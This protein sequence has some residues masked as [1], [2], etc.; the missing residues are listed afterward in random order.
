MLP[1][2]GFIIHGGDL[3]KPVYQDSGRQMYPHHLRVIQRAVR[4]W[5]E[6]RAPE[7]RLAIALAH[8]YSPL[9]QIPIDV[10]LKHIIIC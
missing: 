5:V 6:K 7:R 10:L 8:T 2:M 9:G 3:M 4:V 1:G